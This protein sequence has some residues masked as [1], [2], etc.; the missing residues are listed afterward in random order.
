[1]ATLKFTLRQ[2]VETSE[3]TGM[4]VTSENWGSIHDFLLYFDRH[5]KPLLE[6]LKQEWSCEQDAKRFLAQDILEIFK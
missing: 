6:Q 4:Q 1:M 5:Y 2:L 3:Q